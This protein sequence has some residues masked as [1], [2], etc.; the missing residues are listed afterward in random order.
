MI[1]LFAA[2]RMPADVAAALGRRQSGIDAARWNPR[3]NLHLTLRFFGEVREDIARDL[4][5][6][7]TAV[8]ARPFE[9]TLSG[10][11]A[12]GEGADLHV[13][14]AGVERSEPL[15]QLARACE[16]AARRVGLKAEGRAYRPH[17]TLAYLKRPDPAEVGRW[18]QAN[19]LLKS[20]PIRVESFGLFS[21]F[22]GGEQAHHRLEAEYPLG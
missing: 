15:E 21:S 1:R 13:V 22:L 9:I 14:W 18:I 20:P 12:F 8:R 4:D 19:N 17:V 7:L 3:E 16:T 10:V 2:L 11:G 5:A 6:E